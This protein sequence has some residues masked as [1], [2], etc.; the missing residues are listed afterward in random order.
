MNGLK[1][2]AAAVLVVSFSQPSTGHAMTPDELQDALDLRQRITIIDVRNNHLYQDS[3]IPGAINV[4]AAVVS[5]KRLPPLGL[6]VAYGDGIRTDLT[7]E[8]LTALNAKKGIQAEIL[9]GGFGA[10]QNSRLQT[11]KKAGLSNTGWNYINYKELKKAAIV[12]P[13]MVLVDLRS[14]GKD[15]TDLGEEFPLQSVVR[16]SHKKKGWNIDPC[17]RNSVREKLFVL[18]DDGKED[19]IRLAR[20]L[21]SAGIRRVVLLVGGEISLARKGMSEQKTVVTRKRQ[22]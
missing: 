17:L 14:S 4:P 19:S 2:L 11:T 1:Y 15:L 3:H 22:P 12:N 7:Q 21:T 5:V 13:E 18:I 9:E 10:W 6:V 16:L 8:A 20:Q